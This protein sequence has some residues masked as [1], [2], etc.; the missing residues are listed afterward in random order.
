MDD[1]IFFD[2]ISIIARRMELIRHTNVL[3]WRGF[4]LFG[5][6]TGFGWRRVYDN[7][8]SLKDDNKG[9]RENTTADPY[10]M[11]T[12]RRTTTATKG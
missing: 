2:S 3:D 5:G 10:G 11:T 6:L 8:R 7:S 12:K 9:Q 4:C 1:G